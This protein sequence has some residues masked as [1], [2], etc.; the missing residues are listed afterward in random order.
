M[1]EMNIV[2]YLNNP[3][4]NGSAI[5]PNRELVRGD[6]QKRFDALYTNKQGSFDG[7]IYKD[8]ENYFIHVVVPS[9]SVEKQTS[10]DVVIKFLAPKSSPLLSSTTIKEYNIQVF[11]NS[12]SFTYTY[13][14]VFD[15]EGLLVEELRN[16]YRDETFDVPKT[17]N[18]YNMIS[19]EKSIFM[20]IMY[21]L[22]NPHLLVKSSFDKADSLSLLDKTIRNTDE[23]KIEGARE[24]NRLSELKSSAEVSKSKKELRDISTR[25]PKNRIVTKTTS[26]TKAIKPKS[27]IKPKRK[28][29]AKDSLKRQRNK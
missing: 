15:K 19:Y 21:I 28:V 5:I 11:S 27:K 3:A 13:A 7:G 8:E 20:A 17:R 4:G 10:Y 6:L 24:K 26:K 12:P 23:I 29:T 25:T 22:A 9:E 2:S 14:Y 18:P 1:R 16:K